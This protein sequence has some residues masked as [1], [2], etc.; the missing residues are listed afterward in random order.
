MPRNVRNVEHLPEF[1]WAPLVI[2]PRDAEGFMDPGSLTLV[3]PGVSIVR[4][5]LI[6]PGHLRP[7]ADLLRR[8][9]SRRSL[10]PPG[11]RRP[12]G[13][14]ALPAAASSPSR[15]WRIQ[16]LVFFPDPEVG[17]LPF[18]LLAAL[19]ASRA[20]AFDAVYSTSAPIT[21]HLVAAIVK[22]VT[23]VPWVAEFRDP[24]VGNPVPEPL[25]W[26]HR[27]MKSR[28]ERWIVHTADGLVFLSP[29]T[30]RLYRARYPR[31]ST[32]VTITNGYDRSESVRRTSS[33]G[34]SGRF[35][36]V[37]AGTL[38]R[39]EELRVFLEG[40]VLL[41]R[42]RPRI[43]DELEVALYGVASSACRAVAEQ[44][45]GDGPLAGVVTFHGFV[46]RQEAVEAVAGADAAL[47]MLGTGR[48]M[49]QFVPGK[50]F[51]IIGLDQQV[52]GILPPGDARAILEELDWGVLC[53]PEAASVAE[54]VERLLAM[55]PPARVAD[56]TGRYD[57]RMLVKRLAATLDAVTEAS[58]RSRRTAARRLTSD[59]GTP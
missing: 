50:L 29:S 16:R 24:W 13:E 33:R 5:R 12:P 51:E 28:L 21:S 6:H 25:P 7:L 19:R 2:A 14:A 18:A 47:V 37:W 26:F 49:G 41:A 31:A 38:Y 48:G 10:L 8:A 45:L 34:S 9:R 4:T 42:R 15:M 57:R 46:P 30:A 17:W 44:V 3:A 32:M 56:P 40:L 1:G 58:N 39:P 23:G 55:T 54:A 11:T 52:L 43:V 53:L 59:G 20:Q 36:I 22:L 35:R 27:R